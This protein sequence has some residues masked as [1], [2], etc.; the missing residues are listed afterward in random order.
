MF[1]SVPCK[2]PTIESAFNKL[3]EEKKWKLSAGK[4]VED[5]L[6]VF[7]EQCLVDHP[8]C[9]M[10]L[11]LEDKTY[12][13]ECVFT[14]AEIEE[15]K[16]KK[17]SIQF[18]SHIPEKL[19]TY[20]NAFNL[21]NTQNLR[22]ELLKAQDWKSN[23][24]IN[25]DYDLDWVKHTIYSFVRL[26]ESGNLKTVHKEAWCNTR[27]WSLID[28]IFDDFESLQVVRGEASSAATTKRKNVDRVIDSEDKIARSSVGY[29]CNLIIRESKVQHEHAYE[30]CV[31]GTAI[32][33]QNTKTL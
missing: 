17:N 19:A 23:Y 14:E 8:A 5:A 21:T 4:I 2:H 27:V 18:I 1:Y 29:K 28:T 6:Y 7:G 22:D 20:I 30:Y 3:D 11:D 32:Q 33:Y 24:S 10:I 15:I 25:K 26:Y 16:K 13:K 9:S 31:G 12:L